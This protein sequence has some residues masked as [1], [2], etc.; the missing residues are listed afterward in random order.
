MLYSLWILLFLSKHYNRES[1]CKTVCLLQLI[2]YYVETSFT[3]G[4]LLLSL[5]IPLAL[6][7]SPPIPAL[8]VASALV[9]ARRKLGPGWRAGWLWA[10]SLAVGWGG[11][12]WWGECFS[13]RPPGNQPY[14]HMHP[15]AGSHRG[16]CR[17]F[18]EEGE[19]GADRVEYE[20]EETC[21]GQVNKMLDCKTKTFLICKEII[22]M[23]IYTVRALLPTELNTK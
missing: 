4:F 9:P 7:L 3:A 6:P 10:A 13:S 1:F 2:V 5:S 23:F 17:T 21:G 19:T 12:S 22:L 20:G 16:W 11:W 18:P 14:A 8:S 15:P